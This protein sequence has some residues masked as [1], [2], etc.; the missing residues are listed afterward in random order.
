MGRLDNG[1][2]IQFPEI[3]L[4][5]NALELL[6]IL[7]QGCDCPQVRIPGAVLKRMPDFSAAEA[8]QVAINFFLLF[9][10][11]VC[12]ILGIVLGLVFLI[13][14]T[15]S[16]FACLTAAPPHF[17]TPITLMKFATPVKVFFLLVLLVAILARFKTGVKL[18]FP[19][20]KFLDTSLVFVSL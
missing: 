6:L 14:A 17:T 2:R 16:L 12:A 4:F 20:D 1:I 7:G 11:I 9:A 10:V 18:A 8:P 15:D 19:L 3:F 13:F 5:Q